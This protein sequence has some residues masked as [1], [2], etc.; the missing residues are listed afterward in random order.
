MQIAGR[1]GVKGHICG[2]I[3]SSS[4]IWEIRAP[5]LMQIIDLILEA[6]EKANWSSAWLLHCLWDKAW[7]KLYKA[8]MDQDQL[9]AFIWSKSDTP[10]P[11]NHLRDQISNPSSNLASFAGPIQMSTNIFGQTDYEEERRKSGSDSLVSS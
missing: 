8:C 2:P 1:S 3:H 9:Q 5:K 6:Q 11:N 4:I 10:A 7:Y